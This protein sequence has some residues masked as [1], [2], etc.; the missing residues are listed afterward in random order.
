M[1]SAQLT[2]LQ[3]LVEVSVFL[4]LIVPSM[5]LSLFVVKQGGLSFV[6]VA[7]ATI[8]R[9]LALVSLILLFLWRNGEPIGRIGWTFEN[10]WKDI[11]LG[12]VLF[13]PLFFGAGLLESAFRAAGL[14]APSTPLPSFLTAKGYS[15]FI[16]AFVLVVVVALAEETIFRGY[17]ILRFRNIAQSVP[18]AIILSAVIFSLGHGYEGSAGIA[19]VGLMGVALAIVYVWRRSLVAPIVMHFLQDFIGIVLLPL[20][21]VT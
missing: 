6:L 9:D 7:V 10:G 18:A 20:L 5:V 15:E 16:L 17:L 13:I 11:V 1:T 2:R 3:Q 19:T 4:F 12:V 21:G 14:S 8:L